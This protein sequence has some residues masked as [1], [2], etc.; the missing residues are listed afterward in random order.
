MKAKM[1]HAA[2]G[3]LVDAIRGIRLKEVRSVFASDFA[4]E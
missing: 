1:T 2:R 3:E 4:Q